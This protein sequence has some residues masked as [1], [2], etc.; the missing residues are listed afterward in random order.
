MTNQLRHVVI[1]A[2]AGVF[3]MHRPALQLPTV[4]LVAVSDVNMERGS[5]RAREL[6][7]PF[8]ND[9]HTM[10]AET[11][12]D[13][14]VIL[15]PHP[16]HA[17]IAM[18]C[19]QAGCHV[20]VEKPMAVQ[21]Q[22]ADAMIA[23]AAAQQKLLAV[24]FQRRFRPEVRAIHRLIQEGQLGLLLHAE[25][26]AT[27]PR[28]AS[29]Y[30][31]APWRGTWAGEGGGVLMNQGSHNLD[32]LCYLLGLPRRLSAWTRTLLH[33]IEVEDTVQ[34]MLEWEQGTL[35]SV[36]IS[37][38]EA[39]PPEYLKIVGTRASLEMS[40]N[41]LT[42]DTLDKD[43]REYITTSADPFQGL[44]AAQRTNRAIEPSTDHHVLL[45]Q[46]F[47]EAIL[48]GG[49]FEL[50]GTQGRMSLE[51]ANAMIYSSHVRAEVELPLDRQKYAALLRTLQNQ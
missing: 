23:A 35:G 11:R 47:H 1:G 40:Q 17:T 14:A 49:D 45:Y 46:R 2:G 33:Q 24:S 4:D 36:H 39:G 3:N 27:W 44:A 15:T 34:A 29:Y 5:A 41:R 12:P 30:R 10:L 38:A 28:P 31:L 21:V 6:G 13:V 16:L 50:D 20:L 22:E 19:L 18:A 48:T 51:L 8:Y 26:H 7:C 43:L 9:Y 37:T 25:L 42:I 32:L